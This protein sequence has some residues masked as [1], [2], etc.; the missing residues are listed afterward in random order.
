[1][2][3]FSGKSLHYKLV[4]YFFLSAVVFIGIISFIFFR[5]EVNHANSKAE[6]MINQLI[7]TVQIDVAIAVYTN[8]SKVA[9]VLAKEVAEGLLHNDVVH[10]SGDYG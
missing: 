6:T 1:M 5:V 3:V 9:E 4:G 10:K 7:D 2:T 8:D